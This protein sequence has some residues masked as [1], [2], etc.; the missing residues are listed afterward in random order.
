MCLPRHFPGSLLAHPDYILN[1]GSDGL[2][3][4]K[5]HPSWLLKNDALVVDAR[6]KDSRCCSRCR[7]PSKIYSDFLI[8]QQCRNACLP[9]S[10][11]VTLLKTKLEHHNSQPHLQSYKVKCIFFWKMFKGERKFSRLSRVPVLE[12]RWV[13]VCHY[14]QD[15]GGML[16]LQPVFMEAGCLTVT[17][18]LQ[19]ILRILP[20]VERE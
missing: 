1:A 12:T 15:S 17:H 7:L 10:F 11:L 3:L 16:I 4:A 19:G 13:A 8:H 20:L 9:L 18:E 6:R 5:D 2:P 14:L